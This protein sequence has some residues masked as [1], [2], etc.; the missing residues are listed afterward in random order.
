MLS[1]ILNH[2]FYSESLILWG[3]MIIKITLKISTKEYHLENNGRVT[4]FFPK[5]YTQ[6][7]GRIQWGIISDCLD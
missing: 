1:F 4:S 7:C 5:Y 3:W 6:A 2:S